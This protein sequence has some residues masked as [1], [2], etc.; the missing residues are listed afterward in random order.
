MALQIRPL[1]GFTFPLR[2]RRLDFSHRSFFR[3]HFSLFSDLR[4]KQE[5]PLTFFTLWWLPFFRQDNFSTPF[6]TLQW[7][8][9]Q[10]CEAIDV[11]HTLMITNFSPRKIFDTIFQS[12]MIYDSSK[13]GHWLFDTLIITSS[14]R[15]D[16]SRKKF[17]FFDDFVALFSTFFRF[18]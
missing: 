8:T 7:F 9:T 2:P 5:R 12:S 17:H 1:A 10:T 13:W 16:K 11:F 14:R 15:N 4:L 6:F 18:F 3:E